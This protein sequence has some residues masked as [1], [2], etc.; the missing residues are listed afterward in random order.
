[1]GDVTAL[2]GRSSSTAPGLAANKSGI[3][4]TSN[5]DTVLFFRRQGQTCRIA[6]ADPA[7]GRGLRALGRDGGRVAVRAAEDLVAWPHERVVLAA[8][9]NRRWPDPITADT[10]RPGLR[11]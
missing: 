9:Q 10:C 5:P 7:L 1:M 2:T 6:P 11:V 3:W 8:D 4:S